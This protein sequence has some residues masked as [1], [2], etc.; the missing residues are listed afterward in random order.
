MESLRMESLKKFEE[1]CEPDVRQ[2][3]FAIIEPDRPGTR[4]QMLKDFYDYAES[5]QLHEG[6]PEEVRNHFQTARNL[7]IYSWFYYP[8]NVT[9]QL[10][11]YSS[12]EFALR[13]K[14]GSSKDEYP[15]LKKLL[16]KAVKN[17]WIRDEGF[18][19]VRDKYEGFR[20]Y[21]GSLPPQW[22]Q[23]IPPF[24]Q[25][26]CN[27]LVETMPS[28]RN[29]LMHGSSYLSHSGAFTVRICADLINQ[30]FEKPKTPS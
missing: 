5:I 24:A 23:E 30:L 21:N 15:G 19:H 22:R 14:A 6:A 11:A 25:A 9:A 17:N 27:I 16:K 10:S 20:E 2:K 26:Y 1:I 18:L 8:F 7:I 13:I 28:L 12:L 3:S 4:P 29:T